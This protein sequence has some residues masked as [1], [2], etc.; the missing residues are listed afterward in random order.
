MWKLYIPNK[1]NTNLK[2]YKKIEKE[3]KKEVQKAKRN[4]DK[5]FE[6]KQNLTGFY[7]YVNSKSKTKD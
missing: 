4:M 2:N 5:Q 7:T 1:T 6:N 3:T